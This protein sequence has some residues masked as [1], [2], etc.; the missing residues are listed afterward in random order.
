MT[1]SN[2]F[3][4]NGKVSLL[5]TLMQHANCPRVPVFRKGIFDSG[6]SR[7]VRLISHLAKDWVQHD[8]QFQFL[9]SD[10]SATNWASVRGIGLLTAPGE[11]HGLAADLENLIRVIKRHVRKLA[12][13]H[14]RVDTGFLCFFGLFVSQWA[15]GADNAGQGFTTT[16]PSEIETFRMAAMSRY[17]QEQVRDAIS[18]AHHTTSKKNHRAV[19]W[20][21]ISVVEK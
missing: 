12:E 1:S 15:F 3:I 16:M 7:M 4:L 2:C 13:D 8:L 20:S 11:F 5:E 18:R 14:P 21:S 9:V 6:S 10:L 19:T 17:L